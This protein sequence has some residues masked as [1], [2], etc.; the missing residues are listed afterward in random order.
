MTLNKLGGGG[1]TGYPLI[2]TDFVQYSGTGDLMYNFGNYASMSFYGAQSSGKSGYEGDV[3][4]AP[5][6]SKTLP[7]EGKFILGFVGTML[8]NNL[9][10]GYV[11]AANWGNDLDG[12]I[13]QNA[14]RW[15]VSS[16]TLEV[17]NNG[18]TSSGSTSL[19]SHDIAK[20]FEIVLDFDN[21][22]T[23][24]YVNGSI[25]EDSTPDITISALPN[26]SGF[27]DNGW[28]WRFDADPTASNY[29]YLSVRAAY[30]GMIF[31]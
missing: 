26:P 19:S 22:E 17:D 1:G 23:K 4:G 3:Q 11:G 8:D 28:G 5:A 13:P 12:S 20:N 6:L 25:L 18:T 10:E 27:Y 14:V 2:Y 15:A 7:S 9:T 29:Y 16:G 21:N 31:E 30:G 24:G